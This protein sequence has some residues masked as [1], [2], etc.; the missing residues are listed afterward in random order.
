MKRKLLLVELNE[1]NKDLLKLGAKKFKLKSIKRLLS[2]DL[3]MTKSENNK[4][5]HGL[6][7]WVQWVSIHTGNPLSKHNIKHLGDVE[8]L[9]IKQIWE[10]LGDNNL[11]SGIWGA[12][13]AALKDTKCSCFF[14]P[15]PWTFSET[16][17]PKKLN[18]FLSLPRYYAKNYIS[19][20]KKSLLLS[21]MNLIKFIISDL[22]FLYASKEIFYSIKIVLFNGIN[23]TILFSLFD[24]ISHK[25]FLKYKK[26]YDPNLSIIFLNC[27]AH[28]QHES[29]QRDR[30]NNDMK[31]TLKIV[32]KILNN[33]F[34]EIDSK[35]ALIVLN[36][37]GQK[38]VE[39]E[40]YCI[41]RQINPKK[42][43]NSMNIKFSRL[44]QCM[45]NESHVFFKKE[46]NMKDAYKTLKNAKIRN[47]YLFH[48]E[49][50]KD[51]LGLFY[52]L[53]CTFKI[54]EE[55][56]FI[57]KGQSFKFYKYFSL[58]CE[59]TGSHVPHGELFFKNISLAETLYNHNLYD[60]ILNY[61]L[62]K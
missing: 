23:N 16:A 43:L 47:K 46:D 20:S 29:W 17:I 60:F 3:S 42:F 6:D 55:D 2:M 38:N 59:R 25:I 10:E 57:I 62:N 11:S 39:G 41:Y 45:T 28:A 50:K 21:F 15:D 14:L 52:Q 30:I 12:M 13:N 37:L 32:D 44:E 26:K 36:A 1:F 7:P 9:E 4:E 8:N 19:P 58:L 54:N 33:I 49:Y 61:F 24:L 56:T 53:N 34:N 27:L 40:E 48:V 22:N 35:E 18:N 31:I 5:H 51:S